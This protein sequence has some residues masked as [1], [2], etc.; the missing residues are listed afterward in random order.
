MYG[1]GKS[2]AEKKLEQ[3][4]EKNLGVGGG[5]GEERGRSGEGGRSRPPQ[6]TPSPSDFN[7]IQPVQAW[8]LGSR[9]GSQGE[10]RGS[11]GVSQGEGRG[12]R[13][14]SQQ[15]LAPPSHNTSRTDEAIARLTGFGQVRGY[16]LATSPSQFPLCTMQ[17][18]DL[19][20]SRNLSITVL[21]C[22]GL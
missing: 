17:A 22:A 11:R 19:S 4:K 8:E 20:Q 1:G 9:G 13:G 7:H 18:F 14:G 12:S 2:A 5:S 3:W 21:L 6:R 10:G 16:S 15:A